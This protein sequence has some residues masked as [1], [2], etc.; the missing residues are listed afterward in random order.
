MNFTNMALKELVEYINSLDVWDKEA[1]A[2]LCD[3]ADMI[4]EWEAADGETFESV[5]YAAA[6][7]LGVEI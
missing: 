5:A 1:I 2:N 7:K 6:K 4:K 3:R